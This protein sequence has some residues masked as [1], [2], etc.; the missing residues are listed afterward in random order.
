MTE[1]QVA[2]QIARLC[3]VWGKP[4]AADNTRSR[5]MVSEYHK[6]LDGVAPGELEG[7]VDLAIRE[8]DR[9]PMPAKLRQLAMQ[10]RATHRQAHGSP[11]GRRDVCLA[12]RTEYFYAGFETADGV[13]PR[14]RCGCPQ[15]SE[16]WH[17]EA[18]KAWRETGVVR[19][20][21]SV[22]ELVRDVASQKAV[23]SVEAEYAARFAQKRRDFKALASGEKK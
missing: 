4:F 1:Q 20:P 15:P 5:R 10:W 14:L 3:D 9:W 22:P 2:G 19:E 11:D 16:R 17:T 8:G 7:A 18:A 12:C 13:A 21:R 6:A 23:A